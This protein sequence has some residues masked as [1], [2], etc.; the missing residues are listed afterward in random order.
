MNTQFLQDTYTIPMQDWLENLNWIL[1]D[2]TT[3]KPYDTG[4]AKRMAE[5][6]GVEAIR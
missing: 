2:G 4:C 5:S 6:L 3:F 1:A